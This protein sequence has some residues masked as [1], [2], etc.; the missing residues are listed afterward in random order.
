MEGVGG[1]GAEGGGPGRQVGPA[2]RCFLRWHSQSVFGRRQVRQRQLPLERTPVGV[3]PSVGAVSARGLGRPGVVE[4]A[5]ERRGEEVLLV[6]DRGRDDAGQL[7][8]FA[9]GFQAGSGL[10]P[11][12]CPAHVLDGVEEEQGSRSEDECG[13]GDG[14]D[15]PGPEPQPGPG[16]RC[17]G[18]R[19][20]VQAFGPVIP[21]APRQEAPRESGQRP[22]FGCSSGHPAL[23]GGQQLRGL[24]RGDAAQGQPESPPR[25]QRR[26]AAP[27]RGDHQHAD[28]GIPGLGPRHPGSDEPPTHEAFVPAE[29]E[30][31]QGEHRN[32]VKMI[33]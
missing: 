27:G 11:N 32:R 15:C 20:G 17:R 16:L 6:A 2:F 7:Q 18:F 8:A 23:H 10:S 21:T 12:Q 28:P 4:M 31:R 29:Q 22:E 14:R 26:Q 25:N 5:P 9:P 3:G 19:R 1:R 13:V 33:R 30:F 24:R